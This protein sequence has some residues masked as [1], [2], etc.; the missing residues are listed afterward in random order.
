MFDFNLLDFHA[1][2]TA[3]SGL[4]EALVAIHIILNK[5]LEKLCHGKLVTSE[6]RLYLVEIHPYL[7]L[8]RLIE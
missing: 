6:A 1:A 3:F 5:H 8:T 4:L 7:E 2:G